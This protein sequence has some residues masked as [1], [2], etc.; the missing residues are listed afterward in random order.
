M[1]GRASV[2]EKYQSEVSLI[3]AAQAGD[4]CAMEYL[5]TQHPPV[6]QSLVK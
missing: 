5:L 2:S 3:R 1:N 4:C 6:L